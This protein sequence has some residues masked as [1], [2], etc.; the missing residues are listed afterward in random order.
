MEIDCGL[1]L[2][3]A[4]ARVYSEFI[5]RTHGTLTKKDTTTARQLSLT[6]GFEQTGAC[7]DDRVARPCVLVGDSLDDE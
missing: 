6:S 4:S 5:H 7:R 1:N 2:S 3:H